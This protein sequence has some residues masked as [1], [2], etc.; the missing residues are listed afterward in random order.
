M[1]DERWVERSETQPTTAN[2]DGT[3]MTNGEVG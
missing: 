2:T 1:Q 3:P